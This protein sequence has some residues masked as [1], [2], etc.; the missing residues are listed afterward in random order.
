MI[1]PF[2]EALLNAGKAV[3]TPHPAFQNPFHLPRC[4]V[5]AA[6]ATRPVLERGGHGARQTTDQATA[7]APSSAPRHPPRPQRG[8]GERKSLSKAGIQH[9]R[10]SCA[11]SRDSQALRKRG[12]PD[13]LSPVHPD[14]CHVDREHRP[15]Y[16]LGYR[17]CRRHA[18]LPAHGL[19]S[20]H[21]IRYCHARSRD[22]R[23]GRRQPRAS[24]GLLPGHVHVVL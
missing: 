11:L 10:G 6:S 8:H 20:C 13:W 9:S 1:E 2:C 15:R 18:H 21:G 16:R 24:D 4:R 7:R 17:H 14:H 22:C 23:R 19:G 3:W 12:A 5:I